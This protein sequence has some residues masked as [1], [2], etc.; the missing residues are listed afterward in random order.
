[1]SYLGAL[2]LHFAGQFQ[3]N[4]STVNN[5]PAHFDN[6][7]FQ[8]SYQAMQGTNMNPPNGWFNPQGDASFRLLGCAITSAWMPKG[9]VTNDPV[10]A[11][12]IADSDGAVPAKLVDL[13]PEQQLVST[14]WGLEVRIAD[15]KGGS[16]MRGTYVPAAFIDIWDRATG[17]GGGDIGAGGD[18]PVGAG[19]SRLGRS[20]PIS[21]SSGAA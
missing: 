7:T 20:L 12:S 9:R 15:D 10:V 19:G 1:M 16:L 14:I 3:A 2:R 13:D 5:D 8:Q 6:A 18:L 17:G 11:C 4:V 21:F